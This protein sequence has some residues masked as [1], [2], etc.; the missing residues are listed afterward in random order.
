MQ[1]NVLGHSEV[2]MRPQLHCREPLAESGVLRLGHQDSTDV[3]IVFAVRLVDEGSKL[4]LHAG[5]L[6]GP[7]DIAEG[8]NQPCSVTP[9]ATRG[10]PVA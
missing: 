5:T 7:T 1:L 2:L 8:L 3:V 9:G 4:G 6:H 10:E